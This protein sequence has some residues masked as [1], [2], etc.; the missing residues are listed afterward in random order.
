MINCEQ[1]IRLIWSSHC[2][3]KLCDLKR[4]SHFFNFLRSS[5]LSGLSVSGTGQVKNSRQTLTLENAN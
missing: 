1:L 5:L 4:K 3:V 2:H